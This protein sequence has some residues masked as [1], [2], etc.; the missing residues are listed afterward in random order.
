[1]TSLPSVAAAAA[2][3][4]VGLITKSHSYG[5]GNREGEGGSSFR[6]CAMQDGEMRV[7]ANTKITL[8]FW[9]AETAGYF[10]TNSLGKCEQFERCLDP[11]VRPKES[12]VK[13]NSAAVFASYAH[14]ANRMFSHNAIRGRRNIE[15]HSDWK[16]ALSFG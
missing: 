6:A 2:D 12:E 3:A 4:A 7:F 11:K 1:M 5:N 13:P 10:Q 16:S 14:A 15:R 9:S 8:A